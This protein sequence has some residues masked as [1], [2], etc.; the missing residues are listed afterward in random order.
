MDL[1]LSAILIPPPPE[2]RPPTSELNCWP[3]P[4]TVW[5]CD[6]FLFEATEPL[7]TFCYYWFILAFFS[8]SSCLCFSSC[9]SLYISLYCSMRAWHPY[10]ASELIDVVYWEASES[11]STD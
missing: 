8:Y 2:N 10:S 4:C 1:A 11:Y 7:F 3:R 6:D 5:F 9:L